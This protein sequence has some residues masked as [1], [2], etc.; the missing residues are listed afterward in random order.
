MWRWQKVIGLD[1]CKIMI[2]TGHDIQMTWQPSINEKKCVSILHIVLSNNVGFSLGVGNISFFLRV[3]F[4]PVKCCY[5]SSCFH[6]LETKWFPI[7]FLFH[8]IRS[9]VVEI[10]SKRNCQGSHSI[11]QPLPCLSCPLQPSQ[12]PSYNPLLLCFVVLA[13]CPLGLSSRPQ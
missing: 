4:F 6:F 7:T 13:L 2:L 1:V 10:R 8:N 11:S 3:S 9:S 12:S 5:A